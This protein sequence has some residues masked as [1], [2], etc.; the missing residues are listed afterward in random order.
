[1]TREE[2]LTLAEQVVNDAGISEQLT[3]A[4][5][6]KEGD[7]LLWVVGTP[8]VGSGWTVEIDDAT[9]TAGSVQN[10]GIR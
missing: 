7:R 8:T 3:V 5:V 4:M 9:G 1:M 2:A 10:W 6:R